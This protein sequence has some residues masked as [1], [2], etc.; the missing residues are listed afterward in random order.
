MRAWLG[1]NTILFGNPNSAD[2][3]EVPVGSQ[4]LTFRQRINVA[5]I[6]TFPGKDYDHNVRTFRGDKDSY[7]EVIEKERLPYGQS[8]SSRTPQ[9]YYNTFIIKP[10]LKNNSAVSFFGM[11]S[12]RTFKYGRPLRFVIVPIT[13][14]KNV[15]KLVV[16]FLPY[17]VESGFKQL[18]IK[19]RSGWQRATRDVL[20]G[21]NETLE[22]RWKQ[23]LIGAFSSIG[24]LIGALGYYSLKATRLLVRTV[25]SPSASMHEAW[26]A[27]PALG[28]FSAIISVVAYG[29]LTLFLSPL[30]LFGV[31]KVA[32]VKAATVI[33][34]A[35]SKGMPF[36]AEISLIMAGASTLAFAVGKGWQTFKSWCKQKLA[37][38]RSEKTTPQSEQV[39]LAQQPDGSTV[40]TFTSLLPDVRAASK[41]R[42]EKETSAQLN[43]ASALSDNS[44]FVPLLNRPEPEKK[45]EQQQGGVIPQSDQIPS[46]F[47]SSC[48]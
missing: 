6:K 26:D 17:I 27:Y 5:F 43:V 9:D 23:I 11:S 31:A 44:I 30:V 12:F 48:L 22:P 7:R 33:A 20:I 42:E 25:T 1:K 39:E 36:R 32:G 13:T 35:F 4:Q 2:C 15:I 3:A 34:H 47:Q 10:D 46:D 8:D 18:L 38:R 21:D 37:D 24:V 14:L 28:V 41:E 45:E 16:E 40:L 19:S 29:V